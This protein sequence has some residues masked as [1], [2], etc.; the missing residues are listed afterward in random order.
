MIFSNKFGFILET[1]FSYN[2][3]VPNANGSALKY[4]ILNEALAIFITKKILN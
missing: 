2:N 3:N 4:A 1:V